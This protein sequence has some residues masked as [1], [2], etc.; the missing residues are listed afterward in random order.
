MSLDPPFYAS[1]LAHPAAD[2]P[3]AAQIRGRLQANHII[4]IMVNVTNPL[5]AHMPLQGI[6]HCREYFRCGSQTEWQH[7]ID[8]HPVFPLHRLQEMVLR[9][10]RNNPVP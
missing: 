5:L 4:A 8:V 9:V 2:T 10:Y 7:W 3:D 1:L 6:R